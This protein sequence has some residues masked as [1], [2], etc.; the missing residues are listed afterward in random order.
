MDYVSIPSY[1]TRLDSQHTSLAS[2]NSPKVAS[3]PP[4]SDYSTVSPPSPA[5]QPQTPT[6]QPFNI[7][8]AILGSGL[9]FP[10]PSPR[11]KRN[12]P[13][14]LSTREQLSLPTTTAN[15]RRFASKSGPVFWLQDRIEEVVMWKKGWKV[16]V[17]WM[18][19]YAFI[20]EFL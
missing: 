3:A 2:R 11:T 5:Q 6:K 8:S 1:A 13:D 16:T 15:F 18:S 20:C 7:P 19:A 4:K 12:A 17:A 14:L 9:S 10:S